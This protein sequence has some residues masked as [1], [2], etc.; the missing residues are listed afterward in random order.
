MRIFVGW[1]YDAKWVEDYAIPS[2]RIY[3]SYGLEVKTGKELAGEK[4]SEGVKKMIADADATLFFTTRRNDNG[5]GSWSTSDWV[6]DE[7]KH[8]NSLNKELV[9]EFR[10]ESVEYPNKLHDERQYFPFLSADWMQCLVELN[11]VINRWRGLNFRIKLNTKEKYTAEFMDT[12]RQRLRVKDY[13]CFI[14]IR[15]GGVVIFGPRQTTV[16]REGEH[17]VVYTGE[18]PTYTLSS[19]AVLEVD[20]EMGGVWSASRESFTTLE[21]LLDKA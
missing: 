19:G 9:Y 5:D 7:I 11:K 2:L 16:L 21:L 18:L 14:S 6:V 8:A 15:Q 4:I 3:E 17:L 13:K 12:I 20:L 10:E 1:P